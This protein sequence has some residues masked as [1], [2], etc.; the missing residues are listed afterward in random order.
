[1]PG[2]ELAT[3][4]SPACCPPSHPCSGLEAQ[5]GPGSVRPSVPPLPWQ[6]CLLSLVWLW[7]RSDMGGGG[8]AAAML[9]EEARGRLSGPRLHP[10]VEGHG[11][12]RLP[13]AL[14]GD[15]GSPACAPSWCP[16]SH[17]FHSSPRLPP[18]TL[19]AALGHP[20]TSPQRGEPVL[21][22]LQA[23]PQCG[24]PGAASCAQ[25]LLRACCSCPWDP[26][27][28]HQ[29][30]CQLLPIVL[31]GTGAAQHGPDTSSQSWPG[32]QYRGRLGS[33][34]SQTLQWRC[35]HPSPAGWRQEPCAFPWNVVP[36]APGKG[37]CLT[38]AESCRP[39]QWA[40][41][42]SRGRN[43][44]GLP[45]WLSFDFLTDH[46]SVHLSIHHSFH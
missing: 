32:P 26:W 21:R 18:L 25:E 24:A 9:G 31:W 46:G 20:I 45:S 33:P 39:A 4:P 1:M 2:R 22:G 12:P 37:E 38:L 40:W 42:W 10:D 14:L 11:F 7:A 27:D 34:A 19:G 13:A 30:L 44:Q 36:A 17:L 35:S 8:A 5:E 15:A 29:P 28:L 16:R 23:D 41:D 6:I 43:V 3:R